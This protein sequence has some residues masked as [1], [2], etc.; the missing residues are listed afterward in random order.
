MVFVNVSI[1]VWY[2]CVEKWID[3]QSQIFFA[4]SVVVF[5]I[6]A[7]LSLYEDCPRYLAAWRHFDSQRRK[8]DSYERPQR[9]MMLSEAAW[10]LSHVASILFAAVEI[11]ESG[12]NESLAKT[13]DYDNFMS[14]H[15][16]LT[17]V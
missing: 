8:E 5:D 6:I 4:I 10:L 11:S 2:Q 14:Q 16:E 13:C 15:I 12:S 1:I 7:F 9:R 3:F 17:S